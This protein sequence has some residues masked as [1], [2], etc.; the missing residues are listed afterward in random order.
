MRLYDLLIAR[1]C[2][3]VLRTALH[4]SA[5]Q[6]PRIRI[7]H[8]L[9]DGLLKQVS[10]VFLVG[11][12]DKSCYLMMVLSISDYFTSTHKAY[13]SALLSMLATLA[14]PTRSYGSSCSTS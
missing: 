11:G 14:M 10:F 9:L 7:I 13:K 5:V 8:E 4:C 3:A 2:F 6:C 1:L 12:W